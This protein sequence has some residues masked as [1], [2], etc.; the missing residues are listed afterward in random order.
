MEAHNVPL[1]IRGAIIEDDD[2]VFGGRRG[3]F[4]FSS[5]DV[6][7]HLDKLVLK[8]ASA[9]DDLRS[10][11]FEDILDYLENLGAR[12]HLP[13]NRHLQEALQVSLQVSGLSEGILRHCYETVGYFFDRHVVREMVEQTIGVRFLEEW[14]ETQA[15]DGGRA[16]LR[17]FGARSVHIIA[18]NVPAIAALSVVRNA[19]TRSDAIIK[20]PSNDPLTAAAIARTM[21]EMAPEHPLTRHL[22]VAYWKGGDTGIEQGIYLPSNIEKIIAWGGFASVSHITRYL[23]PGIDLITLD[24]KLSSTIIGRDT[25]RDEKTMAEAAVLAAMDIGH[26]NQEACT[27]ARVVYVETGTD[28]A[29]QAKARTFGKMVFDALQALPAHFSDQARSLDPVLQDEVE[30]LRLTS[31]DHFIVGGGAAGAIIVSL[32]DEPVDFA[33]LLGNR[34]ANLVPVDDVETPI[35]AVNAYTQTIGIYPETLK[36]AIRDRLAQQGAQRLVSLGGAQMVVLGG[37]QDGIEPLR[38][39]CRWVSDE[40]RLPE[41]ILAATQRSDAL[42]LAAL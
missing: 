15:L 19:V 28:P 2:V 41:D 20:T 38:R 10:L 13:N 4:S 14:V 31:D 7:K 12:L 34:I 9:L 30:A 23:Q 3:G 18:G 8:R 37:P 17:A 42:A 16:A 29:G 26:F 33:R 35:R 1:V 39:M 32:T 25:F 24:P 40:R 22:S 11:S 21:I 27:N 36:V 6:S 5:P